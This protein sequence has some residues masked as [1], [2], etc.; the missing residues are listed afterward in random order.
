LQEV[1]KG[2]VH[3]PLEVVT[4]LLVLHLQRLLGEQQLDHG[5]E[6]QPSA[7]QHILAHGLV[8][9]SAAQADTDQQNHAPTHCELKITIFSYILKSKIVH[10]HVIGTREHFDKKL[11]LEK[12]RLSLS[13]KPRPCKEAG[14]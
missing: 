11:N 2:G 9:L 6:T 5:A 13:T 7:L 1:E 4:A 10:A 8:V 14:N 12:T 3:L